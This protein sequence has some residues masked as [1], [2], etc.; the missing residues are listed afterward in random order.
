MDIE[1]LSKDE[2]EKLIEEVYDFYRK[3]VIYEE[4]FTKFFEKRKFGSEDVRKLWKKAFN[5]KIIRIGTEHIPVSEKAPGETGVKLILE[6]ISPK[7]REE[8]R[9]LMEEVFNFYAKRKIYEDEL[10]NYFEKKGMKK[11]K[12]EEL[13]IKAMNLGII[14]FGVRPISL[15]D[16]PL[17]IIGHRTV[18]EL[19]PEG[20]TSY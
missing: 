4:D 3:K 16:D 2:V 6:Y 11:D 14:S 5:L 19:E 9:R 10:I 13:W 17:K 12:I 8:I 18:F 20:G 7:E 15:P 1:K